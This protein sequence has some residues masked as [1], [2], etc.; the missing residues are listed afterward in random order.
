MV[1]NFQFNRG[2]YTSYRCRKEEKLQECSIIGGRG[3]G[4][5]AEAGSG[6]GLVARSSLRAIKD[7]FWL[8][9]CSR[10]R[11]GTRGPGGLLADNKTHHIMDLVTVIEALVVLNRLFLR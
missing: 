4:E 5:E 7:R 9:L 2:M 3:E 10:G 8:L 6:L 1:Y 11:K